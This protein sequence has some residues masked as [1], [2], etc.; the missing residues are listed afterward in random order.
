MSRLSRRTRAAGR[1]ER[2]GGE[3]AGGARADHRDEVNGFVG[4]DRRD[5]STRRRKREE[6]GK[7]LTLR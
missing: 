1:G 3:E 4:H 7:H 5:D 2:A 6:A